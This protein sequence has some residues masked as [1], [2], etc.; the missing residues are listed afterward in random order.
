MTLWAQA[1]VLTGQPSTPSH[2]LIEE[3][4]TN[5]HTHIYIHTYI[6]AY[7]HTYIPNIHVIYIYLYLYLYIY[8]CMHTHTHVHMCVFKCAAPWCSHELLQL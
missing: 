6:R 5:T 2:L 8:A 7:I 4:S 1:S 3:D